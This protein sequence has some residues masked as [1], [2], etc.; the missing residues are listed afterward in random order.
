MRL[1]L[2]TNV[3]NDVLD[4][5][6]ALDL[7]GDHDLFATYFQRKELAATPDPERRGAL[8]RIFEQIGPERAYPIAVPS[9]AMPGESVPGGANFLAPFRDALDR[10][11]KRKNN[12]IDALIAETAFRYG[13]VLVTRDDPLRRVCESFGVACMSLTEIRPP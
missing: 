1:M 9:L 12:V 5:R 6:A 4:E 11:A 7:F 8:L 10:E 2:D 3:F 13:L